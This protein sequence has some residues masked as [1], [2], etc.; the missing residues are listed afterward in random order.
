MSVTFDYL[1]FTR[2]ALAREASPLVDWMEA[3]ITTPRDTHALME[4]MGRVIYKTFPMALTRDM[5]PEESEFYAVE[6]SPNLSPERAMSARIVT[7]ALNGDWP[8]LTALIL[9]TMRQSEE[10]HASVMALLM[11]EFVRGLEAV[12]DENT[13]HMD[14]AQ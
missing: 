8:T 1:E 12:S 5:Q 3:H 4:Y 6:F 7:T 10:F 2:L 14:G 13:N 11:L 9:A